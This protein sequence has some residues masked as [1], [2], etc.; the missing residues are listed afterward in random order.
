MSAWEARN[1]E[2][3]SAKNRFDT[4][5][6]DR[7]DEACLRMRTQNHNQ[8]AMEF[9]DDNNPELQDFLQREQGQFAEMGED[10]DLDG[11]GPAESA[12][13]VRDFE[14]NRSPISFYL[15]LD[16]RRRLRRRPS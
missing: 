16:R 10:L 15:C 6:D 9:E 11:N 4:H 3:R 5:H 12:A 2:D 1:V 13:P 7:R 14:L 8:M